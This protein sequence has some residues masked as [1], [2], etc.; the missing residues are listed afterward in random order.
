M[1]GL[2]APR[3]LHRLRRRGVL[4]LIGASIL[5]VS[6]LAG[7]TPRQ[8]HPLPPA[9]QVSF[10]EGRLW[11]VDGAGS[12][13]SYVFATL[14][15]GDKR[16]ID[17]PDAVT[18][19]FETSPTV[20]LTTLRDP[21]VAEYFYDLEQLKL[22]EG[23]DLASLIGARSYGTL[24]WHMKRS[25]LRPKDNIR[26]WA[27]WYSMGGAN[28]GFFDYRSYFDHRYD[29]VFTIWL[30]SEARRAGKQVLG[31]LSDQESFDLY[32]EMPL[33]QQADLLRLRLDNYSD[34]TPEVAKVKLYLDG[35]LAT[36][37]AL[38]R[39]YLNGLPPDTARGI[40]R[41]LIVDLNH[42]LVERMIPLMESGPVFVAVDVLSVPGE[43]GVLRDLERRGYTITRLH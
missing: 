35:D 5:S 10:G 29:T 17:L 34:S 9:S 15:E 6:L 31:L 19:A 11:Q 36:L 2:T 23:E 30:A 38:W 43:E 8:P 13:S 42:V 37:D 41:R 21:L 40:D 1:P 18:T 39:E 32:N 7:C 20:A 26:P 27:F 24:T 3:F 25:E 16:L 28:W 14:R 4:L 33:E 12:S 22:P